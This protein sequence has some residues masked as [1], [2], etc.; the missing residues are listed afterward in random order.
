MSKQKNQSSEVLQQLKEQAF[1]RLHRDGNVFVA[2][3]KFVEP[4]DVESTPSGTLRV[5]KGKQ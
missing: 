1:L 4:D 3:G 2:N 5:V